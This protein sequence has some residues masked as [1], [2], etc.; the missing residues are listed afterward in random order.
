MKC[1]RQLYAVSVE[2]S[3][4]PDKLANGISCAKAPMLWVWF[5]LQCS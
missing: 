2:R 1:C 5:V 4:V 3:I